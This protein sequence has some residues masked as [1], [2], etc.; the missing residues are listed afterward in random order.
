MSVPTP[1]KYIKDYEELGFGMFIHWGLY[2]QLECGEWYFTNY[3]GISMQEYMKLADSFTAK[4]FDAKKIVGLAK[5]SGCRYAALTTRHHEGFSLYDTCG[6]NKYD[7]PHSPA[8]RDLVREFVDECNRQGIVPFLYHTTLDW[9][10]KDFEE[11]FDRYLEYLNDSVEILCKNYGKIGGFWFDGNWSKKDADWKEDKLYKM[12]RKYQPEAIIVNNTGIQ[13]RGANGSDELDVLTFEQGIPQGINREGHKKYKSAEMCQTLNST[14]GYSKY[15]LCYKSPQEIINT[16]CTCRRY[17]ANYM[18][19]I[20]P[21]AQGAIV[22]FEEAEM[23]IVGEW[24]DLFG[25]AIYKSRPYCAKSCG[26]SYILKSEDGSA[27]YIFCID[28]ASKGYEHVVLD[29]GLYSGVYAFGDVEDEIE[30]IH[31]LDNREP[32]E[33]SQKGK[34]LTV[35]MV[36]NSYGKFYG[37]RVAKATIKK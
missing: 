14:W 5:D 33:F 32:M 25:E 15:D 21:E 23:R 11:N 34:W 27:L 2:S 36:G 30:E 24:M 37:I 10:N 31:W 20:G 12:I 18:I 26:K 3:E 1:A 8:K 22:P 19:N 13:K 4:D 35:N 9:F 17:G 29:N 6:L 7:A 16:L 28:L